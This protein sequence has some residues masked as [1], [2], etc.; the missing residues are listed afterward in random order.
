MKHLYILFFIT[1]FN[2][3]HA[4]SNCE[5]TEVFAEAYKH[6]VEVIALDVM[7]NSG[8]D[9]TLLMR[10]PDAYTDPIMEGLFAIYSS[11]IPEADSVF[12]FFCIN[13]RIADEEI[14]FLSHDI[15]VGLDTNYAW[16]DAWLNDIVPS[17]HPVI[18]SLLQ[19]FEY[20]VNSFSI[21]PAVR[22]TFNEV[23]NL[24]L[25]IRQ[26]NQI[27]GVEY[28]ENVPLIGFTDNIRHDHIE[29]YDQFIFHLGWG[30]CFSGCIANR[31][32]LFAVASE[33]CG[34]SLLNVFGS[35]YEPKEFAGADCGLSTGLG[36]PSL[37]TTFQI[38][39]NPTVE[40]LIIRSEEVIQY[41]SIYNSVG[42]EVQH[43]VINDLSVEI[44]AG[45]LPQGLY[46]IRADQS[47][48]KSFFKL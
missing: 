44:D 33:D 24:P 38:F 48:V 21:I 29:D 39:P 34:A 27:E 35:S 18:D 22:L 36:S 19:D 28:A 16:T 37:K 47:S 11:G 26:L 5:P 23:L 7:L 12:N 4:Q 25:L 8:T 46:F 42:Q 17:G 45:K 3:L 2:L 41:I 13:N 20:S 15:Y 43:K 14:R 9:D 31:Y 6:Q 10:I 32:W 40:K 30:D 1:T